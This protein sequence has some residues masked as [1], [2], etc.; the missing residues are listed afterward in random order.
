M[1]N[2]KYFILFLH[3]ILLVTKMNIKY[4]KCAVDVNILT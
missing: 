2:M 1:S 3:C 4:L